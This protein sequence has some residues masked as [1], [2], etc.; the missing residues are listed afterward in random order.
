MKI[1]TDFV[2]NSSSTSFILIAEKDFSEE[3]F[4]KAAGILDDSEI[5][6]LFKKLYESICS[7]MKEITS[8]NLQD[9]PLEIQQ[10]IK[11]AKEKDY[12]IYKGRLSSDVDEIECFFCTD[13]FVVESDTLYFNYLECA[14]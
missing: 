5:K 11:T 6:F 13:C 10:R 12:K 1:K 8:F 3:S 9:F 4:L 7:N 2:T 14:W